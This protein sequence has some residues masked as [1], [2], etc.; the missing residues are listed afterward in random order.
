MGAGAVAVALTATPVVVAALVVT[1]KLAVVGAAWTLELKRRRITT[2]LVQ[3]LT[4]H[5][6]PDSDFDLGLSSMPCHPCFQFSSHT[7]CTP[8]V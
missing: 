7:P 1:S 6:W 3:D 8:T 5:D 4:S 2:Y